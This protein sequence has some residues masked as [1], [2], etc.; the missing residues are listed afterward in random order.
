MAEVP[1]RAGFGGIALVMSHSDVF[2][3]YELMNS[4][5]F[6]LGKWEQSGNMRLFFNQLCLL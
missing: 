5:K 6:G 4:G 3:C 2:K 1:E